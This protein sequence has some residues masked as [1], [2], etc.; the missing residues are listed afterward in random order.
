MTSQT[1]NHPE[2]QV[3][4]NDP[5][6]TWQAASPL[7]ATAAKVLSPRDDLYDSY[8][9]QRWLGQVQTA[10]HDGLDVAP[11]PA[12]TYLE[13]DTSNLPRG[14][15]SSPVNYDLFKATRY[16]AYYAALVSALASRSLLEHMM[17][18]VL[19]PPPSETLGYALTVLRS[20]VNEHYP[21]LVR[22]TVPHGADFVGYT[23]AV[24]AWIAGHV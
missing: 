18:A 22:V 12:D 7:P 2:G 14:P 10:H 19:G 17:P 16:A 3:T 9:Y 6:D 1:N 4:P 21:T 20:V 23:D 13:T 15:H 24:D 5:A 8:M 11:F